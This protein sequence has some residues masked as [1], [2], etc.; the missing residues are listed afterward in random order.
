MAPWDCHFFE[1]KEVDWTL[2]AG[3]GLEQEERE[4]RQWFEGSPHQPHQHP[5]QLRSS[6]RDRAP[7]WLSG[8]DVL[9]PRCPTA[10]AF[11][12][13]GSWEQ[14][15][16][17]K[18]LYLPTPNCT[19]HTLH[20][21]G[22]RCPWLGCLRDHVLLIQEPLGRWIDPH[23]PAQGLPKATPPQGST[24][25]LYSPLR[26]HRSA[27]GKMIEHQRPSLL[28]LIPSSP[29]SSLQA[30]GWEARALPEAGISLPWHLPPPPGPPS[31]T[32]GGCSPLGC[33]SRGTPSAPQPDPALGD[34][35]LLP[36]CSLGWPRGVAGATRPRRAEVGRRDHDQ[37]GLSVGRGQLLG[38]EGTPRQRPARGLLLRDHLGSQRAQAEPLEEH[39]GALKPPSPCTAGMFQSTEHPKNLETPQI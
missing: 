10:R 20:S 18:G 1:E 15:W 39:Q 7:V 28:S 36:P 13:A 25:V 37:Q 5:R 23:S 16:R 3:T 35:Q 30:L 32:P 31:A 4:R 8:V 2:M 12:S 34:T 11:S 14:E 38:Q 6:S 9:R 29:N 26:W 17:S 27:G 19:T 33:P 24:D 21:P 22:H